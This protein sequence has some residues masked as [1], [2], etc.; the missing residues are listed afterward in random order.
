MITRQFDLH[1]V[2]TAFWSKGISFTFTTLSGLSVV[3]LIFLVAIIRHK[4]ERAAE[5][6][7]L[8]LMLISI[9]L[10]PVAT[11]MVT[12]NYW[13]VTQHINHFT[14]IQ[15]P[16]YVIPLWTGISIVA[17]LFVSIVSRK[18]V[19]GNIDNCDSCEWTLFYNNPDDPS[20]FVEKRSGLGWTL[21]F[22]HKKAYMFLGVLG[23]VLVLIFSIPS[24]F[25]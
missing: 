12:M 22:A 1:G 19:T 4:R 24:I 2:P 25:F 15:I 21:N 10:Y 9:I 20:L 18:A 3:V 6:T 7:K 16:W 5:E 23:I 17:A 8:N 11:L 14:T 13:I